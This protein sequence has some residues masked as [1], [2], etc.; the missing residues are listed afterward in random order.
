MSRFDLCDECHHARG[1][2]KD[3]LG[4]ND[5]HILWSECKC[6]RFKKQKR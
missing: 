2:H 5:S 1:S 6:V 4:D 3:V